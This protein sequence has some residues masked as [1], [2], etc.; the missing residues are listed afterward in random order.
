M[1]ERSGH[2]A[3]F[4]HMT[5]PRTERYGLSFISFLSESVLGDILLSSM[6]PGGKGTFWDVTQSKEKK[7]IMCSQ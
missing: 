1:K 4:P 7:L 3:S 5:H 6:I 2:V